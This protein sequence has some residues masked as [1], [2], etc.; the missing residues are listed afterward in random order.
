MTFQ[1]KNL[2]DCITVSI[3]CKRKSEFLGFARFHVGDLINSAA[4]GG[5]VKRSVE[6]VGR[7]GKKDKFAGGEVQIEVSLG[8]KGVII[9]L[10]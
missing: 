6:L 2:T 1:V 4:R 7:E 5:Y 9:I 10:G 3:N 8:D